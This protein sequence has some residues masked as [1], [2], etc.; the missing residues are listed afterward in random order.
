MSRII[1]PLLI[2]LLQLSQILTPGD[3][4]PGRG[5]TDNPG[6]GSSVPTVSW[7]TIHPPIRIDSDDDFTYA[8]GVLRGTGTPDDPYIICGWVINASKY[9][10]RGDCIY[11]GNTTKHFV[12]RNCK[13]HGARYGPYI[14]GG[15]IT[16]YNVTNG[17]I[18]D[19][20]AFDNDLGISIVH[21]ENIYLMNITA[22]KNRYSGID[23]GSESN[24]IT[25]YNINASN[26]GGGI[27]IGWSTNILIERFNASYNVGDNSG[28][29][30]YGSS[31]IFISNGISSF[32]SHDGMYITYSSLITVNDIKT[33]NNEKGIRLDVSSNNYLYNISSTFNRISGIYI[34]GSNN[35]LFG[36]NTS[37]NY[38]TGLYISYSSY[39]DLFDINS[40]YNHYTGLHLHH[41]SFNT[42]TFSSFYFNGNYNIHLSTTANNNSIHHNNFYSVEHGVLAWDSG[43]NN[44]WNDSSRFGNYWSDYTTRAP[45]A[46]NNG[47]YWDIPYYINGS[48]SAKDFYPLVHPVELIPPTIEDHSPPHATTGDPF[49]VNVTVNDTTRVKE[50]WVRYW[51]GEDNSS[52]ANMTLN[53][54]KGD[55][56]V[57]VIE[58]PWNS[59]LPLYYVI[60]A[61]DIYGNVAEEGVKYV[62]V[63][64]DDPPVPVITLP[65]EIREGEEV[66]ISAGNSYDNIGIV[67]YSWR[68]YYNNW[69]YRYYREEFWFRFE[70]AGNYT[71]NLTLEDEA[72]NV[73]STEVE[74]HVIDTTPAEIMS[75]RIEDEIITGGEVNVSAVVEDNLGVGGVFF[76]VEF[77]E[78]TENISMVLV[79]EEWTCTFDVPISATYMHY[80]LSVVDVDG[81]W[82]SSEGEFPV[83]DSIPPVASAGGNVRAPAGSVVVFN[84]KGSRDNVGIQ[85]Y[86]WRFFYDGREIELNGSEV[87]FVFYIP[88]NYTVRLTVTDYSGNSAATTVWVIVE[89]VYPP[90]A[91]VPGDLSV[92]VG[93]RVILNGSRSYDPDVGGRVVNYTWHFVYGGEEVNLYGSLVVYTFHMPGVYNVTLSVTDRSG[94]SSSESFHIIVVERVEG[95]G[96]RL[97]G[98]GGGSKLILIG[99]GLLLVSIVLFLLFIRW[100]GG[101]GREE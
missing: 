43:E 29:A 76:R 62:P 6:G 99:T 101:G 83:K 44:H 53:P 9:G 41:S 11:I 85:S 89:D 90:V 38:Y 72:G 24:N 96:E 1:I 65:D 30:I 71:I 56:W 14:E 55:I 32:N 66:K 70:D 63:E 5:V 88:G 23:V 4:S 8:N 100:R 57:G 60:T 54:F 17:T 94:R 86:I 51:F 73:N 3:V 33:Y 82:N 40:S 39:N 42:I 91:V 77:G 28:I 21:G 12:I 31:R 81:N 59:T 87:D 34:V 16:L 35:K 79:G 95:D 48:A 49:R 52:S 27:V 61:V 98:G 93:E 84:G 50:V 19:I 64:D 45:F 67:N 47:I 78:L 22:I 18:E 58:I 15:G 25:L 10:D 36:I 26:N 69:P 46:G 75:V 92:Y 7:Y 80:V 74:F 97:N 2:S 13:L 68:L 37:H 20:Y